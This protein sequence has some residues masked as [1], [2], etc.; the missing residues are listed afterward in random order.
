MPVPSGC[1]G[2]DSWP[3]ALSTLFDVETLP[4]IELLFGN[5]DVVVIAF[6]DTG[7]DGIEACC[8]PLM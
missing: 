8:P 5:A 3:L 6:V 7:T 4:E 2:V 1:G